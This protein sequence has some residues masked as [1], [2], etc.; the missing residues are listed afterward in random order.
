MARIAILSDIHSNLEALD[1][2]LDE[3]RSEGATQHYVLGDIVGY[4]ADPD[5]VVARLQALPE[6][7]LLAGNHD[8]AATGRFDT[9]WFNDVAARAIHWT[10][11]VIQPATRDALA[12]LEPRGAAGEAVLVHGS[13]LDPAAEYVR[14]AEHAARSFDAEDFSLC[15]FGHTHRPT[16]FTRDGGGVKALVPHDGDID[17]GSCLS[18]HR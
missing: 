9:T 11:S 16:V 1:A 2:V 5:D 8:L 18:F 6:V 12:S 4:G 15:F 14:R 7:T 17:E 3:A 10:S 13:L